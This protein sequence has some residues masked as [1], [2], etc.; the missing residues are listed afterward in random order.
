MD[1]QLL[2]LCTKS[3]TSESLDNGPIQTRFIRQLGPRLGYAYFT[4]P[5]SAVESDYNLQPLQ[6]RRTLAD[7]FSLYRLVNGLLDC[8]GLKGDIG[9][10]ASRGTSSRSVLPPYQLRLYNRLRL[11]YPANDIY[12]SLRPSA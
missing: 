8:P 1:R 12:G 5:V 2:G 9:L 11:L 6:P 3:T 7:L 10:T 4:T